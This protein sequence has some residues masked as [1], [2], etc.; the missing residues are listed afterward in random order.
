MQPWIMYELLLEDRRR[1][2]DDID[3]T[4]ID[5]A[6]RLGRPGLVRRTLAHGL[7]R[8][9]VALDRASGERALTPARRNPRAG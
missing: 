9:A 2:L 5:E 1:E 7:A 6:R 8:M 4:R 3:Y